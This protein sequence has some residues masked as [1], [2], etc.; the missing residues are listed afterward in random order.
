MSFK[1]LFSF[2]FISA[3]FFSCSESSDSE[4]VSTSIPDKLFIPAYGPFGTSNADLSVYDF[5]GDSIYTFAYKSVNGKQLPAGA[6]SVFLTH[7]LL[8]IC[9]VDGNSITVINPETFK[10]VLQKTYPTGTGVNYLTS[11]DGITGYATDVY[12]AQVYKIRL[13]DLSVLDTVKVGN[14]P[15]Q[16]E[17]IGNRLFVAN[18]GYGYGNTISVIDISNMTV[19]KTLTVSENPT[20]MKKSGTRLLVECSGISWS[21][22]V[23]DGKLYLINGETATKLDSL[24]ITGGFYSE[25][26]VS[27]N[28]SVF[29]EKSGIKKVSFDA[30]FGS[31]TE[32]SLV[33]GNPVLIGNDL[34]FTIGE[35]YS[36][37][38]KKIENGLLVKTFKTADSPSG[39]YVISFKTVKK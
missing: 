17:L 15:W 2:L 34:K 11:A 31:L 14:Y 13:S 33:G 20:F 28:Q 38:L 3:I 4:E 19:S 29:F 27:E 7:N 5:S 30:K 16:L 8:Y 18:S 36:S 12:Q 9:S 32:V 24:T 26:S 10:E 21:T 25:L 23:V 37:T 1:L 22:P 39:N 6:Q 35:S